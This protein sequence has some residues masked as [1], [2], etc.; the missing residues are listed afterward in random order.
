M[1]PSISSS[2]LTTFRMSTRR[3]PVTLFGF[4][5]TFPS[6]LLWWPCANPAHLPSPP[7]CCSSPLLP[8]T[9]YLTS[10]PGS[11]PHTRLGAYALFPICFSSSLFRMASVA[12]GF[13]YTRPF[14]LAVVL[15]TCIYP[16]RF[17]LFCTHD[18]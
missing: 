3:L 9:Y 5:L 14:S 6:C 13:R 18:Y 8:L 7:R 16:S 1:I 12:S 2:G 4:H 15:L 17:L 10:S 11:L